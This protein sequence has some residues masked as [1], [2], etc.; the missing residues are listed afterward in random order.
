MKTLFFFST[1]LLTISLFQ[2]AQAQSTTGGQSGG[3]TASTGAG[4][5]TP[6]HRPATSKAASMTINDEGASR[7]YMYVPPSQRKKGLGNKPKQRASS[8]TG[9]GNDTTPVRSRQSAAGTTSRKTK[10]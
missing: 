5:L 2:T 6:G 8:P 10:S 1:V 3:S 4:Y 7:G 9:P